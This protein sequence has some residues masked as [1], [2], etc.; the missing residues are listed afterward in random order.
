MIAVNGDVSSIGKLI[1]LLKG[2]NDGQHF[3]L[4]LG[5]ACLS[6]CEGMTSVNHRFVILK[7]GCA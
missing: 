3:F 1:E 5:I 2:V 4:Y 6:F 7:E